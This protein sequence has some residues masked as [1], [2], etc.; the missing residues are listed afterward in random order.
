VAKSEIIL[1]DTNIIIGFLIKQSPIVSKLRNLTNDLEDWDR[2][3]ISVVT[4]GEV[5]PSSFPS[6]KNATRRFL[7][8]FRMIDLDRMASRLAREYFNEAY[9]HERML[10]DCLIGAT[11]V[12]NNIP[13]W[14]QN[15]SDFRR[16]KGIRL[17]SPR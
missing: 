1:C 2:L 14:T 11:A 16:F 15:R 4:Y 5:L 13:V 9:Y 12:A 17:F 8:N 6:D 10:M 3:A 7:R